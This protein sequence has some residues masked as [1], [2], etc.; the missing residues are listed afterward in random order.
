VRFVDMAALNRRAKEAGVTLYLTRLPGEFVLRGRPVAMAEGADEAFCKEASGLID[1]GDVR[2]FEQDPTFGLTLL[3]ETAQRALSPGVNDPGT[4]YEVMGR[5][6]RL[7]W[8]NLPEDSEATKSE[9]DFPHIH[10]PPV[11]ASALLKAS[12]PPIAL[13]AGD[14]PEVMDWMQTSLKALE[15]H[16]NAAMTR[17]AQEMRQDYFENS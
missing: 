13:Y 11:T 8:E 5:L 17:A 10:L 15:H 14:A 2:S 1:V 12:F 9:A 7:L 16:P 6:T 3:A 4:A